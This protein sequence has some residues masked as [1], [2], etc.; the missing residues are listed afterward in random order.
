[1]SFVDQRD[2][3]GSEAPFMLECAETGFRFPWRHDACLCDGCDQRRAFGRVQIGKQGKWRDFARAMA[4]RALA[5]QDGRD[6]LVVSRRGRRQHGNAKRYGEKE[7][8]SEQ[9]DLL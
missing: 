3:L 8:E 1:L 5:V 2:L 4:Q 6:V 9:F 7:C